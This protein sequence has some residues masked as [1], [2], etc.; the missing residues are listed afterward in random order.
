MTILYAIL[1]SLVKELFKAL[2]QNA[3][4][5]AGH[6]QGPRQIGKELHHG[7]HPGELKELGAYVAHLG[8]EVPKKTDDL[9]IDP[10]DDLIQNCFRDKIPNKNGSHLLEKE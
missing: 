4:D 5:H 3:N 6:I 9:A 7:L 2:S 10:V 1:R 8:K